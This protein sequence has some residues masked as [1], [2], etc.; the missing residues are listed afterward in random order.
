MRAWASLFDEFRGYPRRLWLV[1][2]AAYVTVQIEFALWS[3]A[4][5]ALRAEFGLSSGEVGYLTGLTFALGGLLVVGFSVLADRFGRRLM[6]M[7]GTLAAAVFSAL[8]VVATGLVALAV[9]RTCAIGFSGLVF[10][11]TGALVAEEAPARIRGLMVGLL[12]IAVPIGWLLA[13]IIGAVV[14]DDWGW[15]ALF[16]A[17]ILGLPAALLVRIHVRE[18]P[19][20]QPSDGGTWR[21]GCLFAAGM[22]RR[23]VPLFLA[24]GCFALAFG[25]GFILMPLYLHD[26]LGFGPAESG[27]LVAVANAMGLLGYLATAWVGEFHWTRRNTIAVATFAA[28]VTFAVF[29]LFARGHL[30]VLA[31]YALLTF[32]LLGTSAVKFPYIAELYPSELRATGI[33]FASS[34]AIHC[35]LAFGPAIVGSLVDHVGWSQALLLGGAVPLLL[36]SGLFLLLQPLP[37]GLEMREIESRLRQE[38]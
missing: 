38:R 9:V 6:L 33:A 28:A 27:V 2:L 18:S 36:A 1:C 37:S 29:V 10:P 35:G 8:H 19:L 16:L 17:A 25:G 32:F 23:T 7:V 30:A 31:A 24:Q 4:L 14:L 34:L 11:T 3:L 5:P 26:E 15:R 22:W 20:A 12:Q 21:L 13:A